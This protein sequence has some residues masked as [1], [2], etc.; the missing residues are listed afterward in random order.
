MCV[1]REAESGLGSVSGKDEIL[2]PCSTH[3]SS[4]VQI[5][6]E[7]IEVKVELHHAMKAWGT[8]YTLDLNTRRYELSASRLCRFIPYTRRTGAW[9][10]LRAS[11]EAMAKRK[12]RCLY[13]ES[14][15]GCPATSQSLCDLV[16]L[17]CIQLLAM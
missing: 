13:K 17:A 10:D 4:G 9:V 14:N 2:H 8:E 16:Q 6:R 3:V 15:P 1:F 5:W 7:F 12:R 11:L